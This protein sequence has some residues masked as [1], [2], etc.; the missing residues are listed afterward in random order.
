M[1]RIKPCL[2][3]YV[4]KT[5]A[6]TA[7]IIDHAAYLLTDAASPLGVVLHFIGRLTAPIMCYFVAEGY[8]YTK[9]FRR[10]ALRL[11]G[12]AVVSQIPYQLVID[13]GA[14]LFPPP[15]L[16]ML[17]TLLCGL[18]ALR[19]W[20]TIQND[21]L[22]RAA[23]CG[24]MLLTSFMDW[25]IFGVLFVFVF[26]INRGDKKAQ[27][28]AFAL[29][30]GGYLLMRLFVVL[31]QPDQL[32]TVLSALGVFCVIPLL[33][34]YNGRRGGEWAGVLGKQARWLFYIAYP[35]HLLLLGVGYRMFLLGRN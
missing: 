10:Y 34:L 21:T 24:L 11:L 20:N 30:A 17:F 31:S 19:A 9:D 5:I 1:I 2:S 8:F 22:R 27:Y 26:G 7:M 14:V 33:L 23:V 4:L 13:K 6:V 3:G 15:G 32:V 29:V 16:N 35:A 12:F 25:S 28:K 18:L